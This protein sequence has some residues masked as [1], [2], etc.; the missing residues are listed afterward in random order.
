[1][2]KDGG[3]LEAFKRATRRLSPDAFSYNSKPGWV[4][5]T[6]KLESAFLQAALKLQV[7]QISEPVRSTM[8]WHVIF[9]AKER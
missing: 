5:E 3:D 7:G 9:A 6:T 4:N 1:M 8:G 2:L